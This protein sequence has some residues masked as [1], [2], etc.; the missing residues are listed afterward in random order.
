MLNNIKT[1]KKYGYKIKDLS[2]GSYKLVVA[3][4]D[5][6]KKERIVR[7]QC[8]RNLCR[9]CCRSGKRNYG[10]GKQQSKQHRESISNSN[11]GRTL[12]E[13]Q[14][15]NIGLSR[16]GKPGY[17]WSKKEKRSISEARRGKLSHTYIDGRTSLHKMLRGC[18][19]MK[20]WRASVFKRD[21]YICTVC[22]KKSSGNIE[23][24][25]KVSFS[26]ILSKFL[27]KYNKLDA[28]KDKEKLFKFA[29]KYNKFW[30]I[31]NGQTLCKKCHSK[32]DSYLSKHGGVSLQ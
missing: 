31:N 21:N 12:T 22:N 9:S 7:F 19:E 16:L 10:Y 26:I 6:C 2:K 13:Q 25:H 11:K 28:T 24:H 17:K 20:I 30:N 18:V 4:C 3:T 29:L 27:V 14:R 23:S 32:T 1:Y 8:Y 15:K 5:I